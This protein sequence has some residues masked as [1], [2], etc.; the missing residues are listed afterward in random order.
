MRLPSVILVAVFALGWWAGQGVRGPGAATASGPADFREAVERASPSIVHVAVTLPDGAPGPR[1]RDDG[2]GSGFV[3]SADGLVVTSRH[4]VQG[5]RVI[6]VEVPGHGVVAGQVVGH[7][8]S[9]DLTVLRVPLSGLTPLAIGDSRSL[10][11]G[12]WVLAVGSPFRLERSWSAG[13]VSGLNRRQVAVDP[14]AAEGY[15]QT[16][17][18]ANL[19]NSGGPLLDAGGRVVGMITQILTR[20]GGFQGISMATPIEGVVASA[21]RIA[22]APLAPRASLGLLVR[23][24]GPGA[25][26]QVTRVR[27]GSAAQ[28]AGVVPGDRLLTL[29]GQPLASSSELMARVAAAQVGQVVVLAL[30]RD[31]RR[32]ELRVTLAAGAD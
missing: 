27:P 32:L 20:S 22:G 23:E 19:G 15:I 5:A 2:V 24:A 21:R 28:L 12:E 11:I 14:R 26:L 16:D 8:D 9:L 25:G 31:G 7:D 6:A 3:L 10:R 4:V 30:D 17:A 1:S 13:I 29:D 18:A